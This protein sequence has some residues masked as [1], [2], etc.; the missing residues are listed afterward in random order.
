MRIQ[1]VVFAG[2]VLL[3]GMPPVALADESKPTQIAAAIPPA[4]NPVSHAKISAVAPPGTV[5]DSD[6]PISQIATHEPRRLESS[7]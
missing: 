2:L 6:I 7:H 3:A 1:T 4:S 5:E